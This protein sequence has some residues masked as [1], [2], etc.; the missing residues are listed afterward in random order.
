M[1]AVFGMVAL[2]SLCCRCCFGGN[3]LGDEVASTLLECR[4]GVV[5]SKALLGFR[6][7]S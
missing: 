4:H 2:D 7:T 6:G 1:V 3:L 5:C